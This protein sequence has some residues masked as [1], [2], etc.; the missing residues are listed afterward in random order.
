MTE[1]NFIVNA[2]EL[3]KLYVKNLLR[4]N[5]VVRLALF[6]YIQAMLANIRLGWK[7]LIVTIRLAYAKWF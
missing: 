3:K 6:S 2:P 7:C 1:E 4:C 5:K